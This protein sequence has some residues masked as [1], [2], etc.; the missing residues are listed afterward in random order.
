MNLDFE[1]GLVFITH[2]LAFVVQ[3]GAFRICPVLV[4]SN[5]KT[6]LTGIKLPYVVLIIY[7]AI[8]PGLAAVIAPLERFYLCPE[9]TFLF[10]LL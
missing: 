9:G 3:I 5:Y 7:L 6:A 8:F 2:R 4:Y 10:E 1:L